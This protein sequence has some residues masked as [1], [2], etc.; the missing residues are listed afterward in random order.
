MRYIIII[1]MLLLLTACSP[2]A[3]FQKQLDTAMAENFTYSTYES[4]GFSV[5]YPYWPQADKASDVEVSVSRGYCSVV[6]NREKIGADAWFGMVEDSVRNSSERKVLDSDTAGRRIK[7]SSV[8]QNI[9]LINDARVFSCNDYSYLVIVLCME[10]AEQKAGNI[11]YHVF[12]SAK[13]REEAEVSVESQQDLESAVEQ[14]SK[15]IT[16]VPYRQDDFSVSAPYW[17]G[18]E[19]NAS[20]RVF[21]VS[22]GVCSV[23]VNRYNALPADLASWIKKTID[24][25]SDHDLLS[26]DQKGDEYYIDYGFKYEQYDVTART[27]MFYCNYLT[28]DVITTCITN[29]TNADLSAMQDKVLKSAKCAQTYEIP[30]PKVI[31]Q[32]KEEVREEEPEVIEDIEESIVHTNAGAEF[33]I[34]EEMVVYFINNNAF[35]TKIMKDYPEANLRIEDKDQ[36]RTLNL[37]VTIDE[38]TGKITS[39]DDG[40]HDSPDVTLIIPLRDALNIFSNAQNLNPL[41]LLAFAINVKT[42]PAGIKDQVL[43]DVLSGKYK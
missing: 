3:N 31:E 38:T 42:E 36:S 6:V 27:R 35:F 20:E 29:M 43:R 41:N 33:G 23:I 19:G 4:D 34:D 24:E 10:Q 32:K 12:S 15:N 28:Y 21:A 8:Y 37:K 40:T 39:L 25:T 13:C 17:S 9:T 30:T 26:Y 14:I 1:C 2:Q 18:M 5:D 7:Y 22:S 16:Y 11:Y